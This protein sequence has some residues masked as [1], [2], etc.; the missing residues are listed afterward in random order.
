MSYSV[1]KYRNKAVA[2][3]LDQRNKNMENNSQSHLKRKEALRVIFVCICLFFV[4]PFSFGQ[5]NLFQGYTFDEDDYILICYD[6]SGEGKYS[7]WYI[8]DSEILKE[9]Q[10]KGELYQTERIPKKENGYLLFLTKGDSVMVLMTFFPESKMLRKGSGFYEYDFGLFESNQLKT[11]PL[12]SIQYRFENLEKA[13]RFY[14]ELENNDSIIFCNQPEWLKYDGMFFYDYYFMEKNDAYLPTYIDSMT[15]YLNN[16]YPEESFE[17]STVSRSS[18]KAKVQIKTTERLHEKL[19]N[20]P[21][22]WSH[23]L[24]ADTAEFDSFFEFIYPTNVYGLNLEGINELAEKKRLEL[25]E[26]I[27]M[28]FFDAPFRLTFV[29]FGGGGH[30]ESPLQL[31]YRVEAEKD[32]VYQFDLYERGNMQWKPFD[33]KLSVLWKG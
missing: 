16:K 1:Q 13:R 24:L 20:E 7:E 10:K 19:I 17:I 21:F 18:V 3:R 28:Q 31:V 33:L 9:L 32:F 8:D 12:N 11:K 6:R 4:N 14:D 5:N 29:A 26:E 27:R 30:K 22:S 2:D 25:K 15:T 23:H